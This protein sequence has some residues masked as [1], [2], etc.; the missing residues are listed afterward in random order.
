MNGGSGETWDS[1]I[2]YLPYNEDDVKMGMICTTAWSQEVKP[3]IVYPL[4][5]KEHPAIFRPVAEGRVLPEFH[6]IYLTRGK[7]VFE[8]QG[9]THQV[10]AGNAFLLLPNVW[11]KYKP[12]FE[13]GWHE[14]WIGFKGVFFDNIRKENILAPE[15][16]VFNPGINKRIIDA[17]QL[18]FE[19]VK[20]QKPM[21]QIRACSAIVTILAELVT[22]DSRKNQPNY[23]QE[24]VEKTKGIMTANI[25]NN[26]NITEIAARQGI[27]TQWL[28]EIFRKYTL[29][30]PYQY[31]I[32]MKINKAMQ[33]LEEEK[34]S[35]KEVAYKLGFEYR[36][37]FSRLFKN[38]TGVAPSEW[39]KFS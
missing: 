2:H 9:E 18:I 12:V 17:F 7:G 6:I 33:L 34:A 4:R 13:V 29:M 32:H 8:T 22:L 31:F 5:K 19:E 14:H 24:I 20:E 1:F 26:I 39:K 10:E 11:H 3:N 30:T 36:Y 28:N 25:F 37:H 23:Y 21:F 16:T 27:S 15:H 35:V 38:K